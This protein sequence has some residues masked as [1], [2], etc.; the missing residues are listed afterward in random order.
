MPSMSGTD[1]GLVLRNQYPELQ[2]L[3]VSGYANNEGITP[4]LSRL[5]KPVRSDELA[6]SLAN[7]AK[8]RRQALCRDERRQAPRRP[9]ERSQGR[10]LGSARPDVIDPPSTHPMTR[11]APVPPLGPFTLS[12]GSTQI[13]RKNCRDC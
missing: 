5:T 8:V 2:I 4:D 13:G 1:L 10:V 12:G 7:L 3:V 11:T 9:L 6:A